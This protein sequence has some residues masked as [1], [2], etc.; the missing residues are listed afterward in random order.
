VSK[1]H[2]ECELERHI[3]EQLAA[4]GWLV[5]DTDAYDR[6]RA[7]YP[8]DVVGWLRD[9]Q[10]KAWDKLERL[11]GANTAATVLDRLV[12]ALE[13]TGTVG[14]LRRGFAV[15]GGGTLEMSQPLPED[16]RNA[17]VI[18]RY[19]A[20]RLRVV[21]QL[22]YSLDKTDRIDLAF[23][24]NGI[25]VATVELK[26]DF[27]QRV[28]AAMAQYRQ[29]RPPKSVTTGRAEPLLA[30]QRGAVVH[31]AMS[32]S[33]IRMATKLDGPATVF[34]PFNRGNDGAAGN[35]PGADGGYPV[36][37]L[38]QQVLQR[39][40]WLRIFHRFVLTERRPVQDAQGQTQ[41]KE[42]QIFPRFH[43]LEGVT[44]IV[45]KV[46]AE[47][48]GQPYLIQ[49]SA[50]SGKTNTISWTAHELIRIRRPDGEP[51]FHSVIVVTD[52][53]VLDKQLQ[54]AIAQIEHQTGVVRAIDTE[55]SSLPKSQQLAEAMLAG[56]PIIVCT[57]QTF[58]HA[59]KLILAEQSL[60]DRRFAVI[61]DEAHSSTGGSTADDLRYVLTGQS[62]AE[63]EGLSADERLSVWQ[64][65]RQR[66][67]NA[68]YF[69]F[70]ATPKHS[71]LSLFGRPR[72]PAKPASA[73]NPPVPFHLYTMQQAIEEGFILDV[74]RNYTSY[75][76]ALRIGTRFTDGGDDRVDKKA[77]GRALAKWL[78][79]H[80]TNIAQKVQLIAEHFRANVAHLLHGQA[81]A[82]VVTSSRA[83]A[84]KY[85]L[86]LERYARERG[87]NNLHAMVAF[88]GDVP[89]KDVQDGA[90]PDSHAFN[91]V[92]LNPLL[93]GRD[94]RRAFDTRDYRVMIVANKFQT[95]FDQP[96]L[97]AM[98]LDKK[99]SGVEAVQTLSRLN[100]TAAGKDKTFVI[101]FANE[102]Q[103]I[104]AAFKTF[105]RD[106]K[107]SDV[108]DPNIVYDIKQKLDDTLLYEAA[109]VRAFA[110]AVV[111]PGVTHQK[112]YSLTQAPTDRFN[113]KLKALNDAIEQW[114]RAWQRARTDGDEKGMADADAHR[115]ELSKERDKLM[116]FSE[117]LNKFV[118]SYEYV[119]QLVDF[120]D[121]ALEGFASFARLLRKRLKGITA[122][123]VDLS[124]LRLTHFRVLQK[125]G[126]D[127]VVKAGESRPLDPII[128]NG[129]RDAKDREKAYLSEL[130]KRLND[131]LGKEI[132]DTDQVAFAVHV[133]E[134]L[135]GD[136]VVMAQVQNN[137]KEQA[138][139]ANLPAAAV[140]AIYG[141]METHKALATKLLS[142]GATRGVFVD[143][144]YEL[145]KRGRAGDLFGGSESASV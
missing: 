21:P 127:G 66:P 105:F 142:D 43:Q 6:T 109:E 144:V 124:D 137:D 141:A 131:A 106:A 53:T 86:A 94:M 113:S 102:P 14:V 143:V 69:A 145:L 126:L 39:D 93:K 45:D 2:H 57:L 135:R 114:E 16:A 30:F 24:I 59:Q 41:F 123:Q 120:G 11:N 33:D 90:Y 119:A 85:H 4:A 138:M 70:T 117:G 83:A 122:E 13:S 88:S 128:D 68:S 71:T 47:G 60:R 40:N 22:A 82:M 79:L 134:K 62:E 20:N 37:Y 133:S 35:P 118:R 7:L 56:T 108:Q 36:A 129:L 55:S 104:E 139:K 87:Y 38:W 67:G 12:K 3:V 130:V 132:S 95:G 34:L 116:V 29:D 25:A 27:T 26:T 91:E 74:L 58:P 48:T 49:H 9:S 80:P 28:E 92:N 99:V 54:D 107:V 136:A 52:R 97:V 140:Q 115:S 72:D 15:A 19:K 46:R 78:S 89:N 5:G 44:A 64:A 42:T 1:V 76:A 103:E 121:P 84:V 50:G 17:T 75:K 100:R 77:A 81:K 65:S 112:L 51:Y 61:I 73:D 111:D 110:E 125:G 101:D 31:F 32:D 23:F 63:W 10:P 8:D 98:Y 18:E 96:K